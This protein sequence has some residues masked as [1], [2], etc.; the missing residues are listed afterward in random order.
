MIARLSSAWLSRVTW[1]VSRKFLL[2]SGFYCKITKNRKKNYPFSDI[3]GPQ[4]PWMGL[5]KK[6]CHKLFSSYQDATILWPN[7]PFQ[8][9]QYPASGLKHEN[10]LIYAILAYF[11]PPGGAIGGSNKIFG[12][13]NSLTHQVGD[14]LWQKFCLKWIS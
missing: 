7:L 1:K 5:E 8:T 13:L 4:G 10:R 12:G 11:D 2:Q 6:N 9:H 3:F 14:F